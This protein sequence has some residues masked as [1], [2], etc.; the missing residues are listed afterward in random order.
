MSKTR[1]AK[2]KP[3]SGPVGRSH[4]TGFIKAKDK[5]K[6]ANSNLQNGTHKNG[7]LLQAVRTACARCKLTG[8]GTAAG[9]RARPPRAVERNQ[10]V[11]HVRLEPAQAE[12]VAA[13]YETILTRNRF[14]PDRDAREMMTLGAAPLRQV[15]AETMLARLQ[16]FGA[17]VGEPVLVI[18]GLPTQPAIPPTPYRGYGDESKTASSDMLLLAVYALA[19]IDPLAFAF[20]N[21]GQL[22]RNVVPNPDAAGQKSSHGFDAELKWHTDNPCGVH[23]HRALQPMPAARSP[24]PRHLGFVGLRNRDAHGQPVPT[25]VL[26]LRPVLHSLPSQTLA[27]L[28]MHAF[29][30]N[31]PTSNATAPLVG[32]LVVQC[33]GES[34]L[35]YNAD[36][37]QVFGLTPEAQ[38]ALDAL[39]AAL[40]AAE[41]HVLEVNIEPGRIMVFDNYRVVHERT[42]FDPGSNWSNARWMRR[43][44]GCQSLEHGHLVDAVHCPN[45][46][47]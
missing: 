4:R 26:P 31:A 20:E 8:G 47:A 46:W 34:F 10:Y 19:G 45:L 39:K 38:A 6:T 36:P 28:G 5:V 12:F 3:E 30:V 1:L 21:D 27:Q 14:L 29:Q 25:R 13:R 35:R 42:K 40:D 18:E 24:I 23:E 33:E 41:A 17:G 37:A 32:P 15:L 9:Q 16:R 43:V 2:P 44:Y 7:A 11:L 22:F